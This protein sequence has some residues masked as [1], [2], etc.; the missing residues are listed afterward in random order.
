MAAWTCSRRLRMP[1]GVAPLVVL[2]PASAALA[3]VKIL[4]LVQPDLA[5]RLQD[6]RAAAEEQALADDQA[7]RVGQEQR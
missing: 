2:E 4:A 6:S 1:G 3:A 7:V 5:R